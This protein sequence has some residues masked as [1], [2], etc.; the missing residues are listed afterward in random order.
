MRAHHLRAQL[1]GPDGSDAVQMAYLSAFPGAP[2][3]AMFLCLYDTAVVFVEAGQALI[4]YGVH[5]TERWQTARAEQVGGW[6]DPQGASP[7]QGYTLGYIVGF[8]GSGFGGP[9]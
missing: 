2:L 8:L 7:W 5:V 9:Y 4:K 3:A 1:R 6:L